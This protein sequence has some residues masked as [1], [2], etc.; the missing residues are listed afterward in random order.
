MKAWGISQRRWLE[1]LLTWI[2][3]LKKRSLRCW[4]SSLEVVTCCRVL[5][6]ILRSWHLLQQINCLSQYQQ[7]IAMC[8]YSHGQLIGSSPIQ[9]SY[10]RMFSEFCCR[11]VHP[12]SF[13]CW[14]WHDHQIP[15][16]CAGVFT[17]NWTHAVPA[18]LR[19]IRFI[20]LFIF[21]WFHGLRYITVW[22]EKNGHMQNQHVFFMKLLVYFA[23]WDGWRFQSWERIR[24]K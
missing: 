4:E 6:R 19:E 14:H 9:Y 20:N 2:A 11:S 17:K 13:G 16:R 1:N 24:W 7:C 10:V 3:V 5:Q 15:G 8:A 21:C 18:P 23:G 12:L 22:V